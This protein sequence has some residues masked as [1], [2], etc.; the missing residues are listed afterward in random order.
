MCQRDELSP[1][2][3]SQC[4]RIPLVRAFLTL[5]DAWSSTYCLLP[6]SRYAPNSQ[7]TVRRQESFRFEAIT[8]WARA[9]C[10]RKMS[11]KTPEVIFLRISSAG[12]D[13]PD[14]PLPRKKAKENLGICRR[15]G[16]SAAWPLSAVRKELS[17]VSVQLLQQ[18]VRV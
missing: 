12:V 16:T 1:T 10:H 5:P 9:E 3:T 4:I 13:H 8:R 15:A 7:Q 11:F 18:G 6:S 17:L 2:A 14:R